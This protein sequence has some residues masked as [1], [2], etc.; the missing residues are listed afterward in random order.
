MSSFASPHYLYLF[1]MTN[2]KRKLA[3]GAS[4]ED[5]YESLKLRLTESEMAVIAKDQYLKVPQRDLRQHI[6]ELG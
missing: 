1:A 5:A 2:G 4:P 6:H 3:Y